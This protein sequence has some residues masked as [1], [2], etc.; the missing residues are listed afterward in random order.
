MLGPWLGA[1]NGIAFGMSMEAV[2]S[3]YPHIWSVD[4]IW[5]NAPTAVEVTNNVHR[6]LHVPL[7]LATDIFPGLPPPIFCEEV[8]C[9]RLL[10]DHTN[11]LRLVSVQLHAAFQTHWTPP[12]YTPLLDYFSTLLGVENPVADLGDAVVCLQ[13]V[14]DALH[15]YFVDPRS[16]P[17][18]AGRQFGPFFAAKRLREFVDP[19]CRRPDVRSAMLAVLHRWQRKYRWHVKWRAVCR[20][21][22]APSIAERAVAFWQRHWATI[23]QDDKEALDNDMQSI[24]AMDVS[25]L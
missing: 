25:D 11:A 20:D 8:S 16:P 24:F 18:I 13:Y 19:A 3:C 17:S 22:E 7:S 4:N 5:M 6:E 15:V 23:S 10:F 21:I 2:A 12:Q 9:V 14:H 1:A